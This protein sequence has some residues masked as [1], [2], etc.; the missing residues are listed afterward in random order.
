M[1]HRSIDPTVIPPLFILDAKEINFGTLPAFNLVIW[2]L[3]PPFP[4]HLC[5]VM[6]PAKTLSPKRVVLAGFFL[7]W[8]F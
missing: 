6:T 1:G 7:R 8:I 3:P 4:D 2:A 5:Q